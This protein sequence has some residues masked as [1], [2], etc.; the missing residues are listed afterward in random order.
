MALTQQQQ[1]SIAN[2][3]NAILERQNVRYKNMLLKVNPQNLNELITDYVGEQVD[4]KRYFTSMCAAKMDSIYTYKNFPYVLDMINNDELHF[5]SLEKNGPNDTT[6]RCMYVQ[7]FIADDYV[8]PKAAAQNGNGVYFKNA[9]GVP[10][11]INRQRMHTYICCFTGSFNKN[12]HWVEYANNETGVCVEMSFERPYPNQYTWLSYG[13]VHYDSGY[14]FDFLKEINLM[15]IT[16]Y[17]KIFTPMG[18][19][20]M[21][22]MTKR[23]RYRWED[24]LRIALFGEDSIERM[25]FAEDPD[26]PGLVRVPNNNP[27]FKW[28]IKRIIAGNMIS[29]ADL[30]TLRA[31]CNAKNIP[32]IV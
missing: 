32:L 24:E 23:E 18:I 30:T 21:A 4:F 25:P 28:T 7:P 10:L 31:A 5:T 16:K 1:Q 14:D 19:S 15:M 13:R 3:I 17:G 6:L 27:Y 29:Q 20:K 11:Q 22:V 9:N 12:K 8:G 26:V 2:D